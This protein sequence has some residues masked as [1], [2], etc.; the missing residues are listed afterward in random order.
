MTDECL[1]YFKNVRTIDLQETKVTYEGMR[2]LGRARYVNL[3][4]TRVMD[5]GSQASQKCQKHSSWS[6][7]DVRR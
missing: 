2:H 1:K 6:N 3:V 4:I 5:E 7:G